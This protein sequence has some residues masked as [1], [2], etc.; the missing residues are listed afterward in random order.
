MSMSQSAPGWSDTEKRTAEGMVR[1]YTAQLLLILIRTR[2]RAEAEGWKE[3]G[4]TNIVHTGMYQKVHEI[5]I[6]LQ[7]HSAGKLCL[8]DLAAHFYQPFLF[9]PDFPNSYRFYSQ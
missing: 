3:P 2:S 5:A 7:N 4:Q 1:L 6:Y 9:D 8:D